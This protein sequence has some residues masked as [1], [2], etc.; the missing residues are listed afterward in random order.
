MLSLARSALV[1]T[2]LLDRNNSTMKNR[3]FGKHG[4]KCPEIG[5]GAWSIGGGCWGEQADIDSIAALNRV[6]YLGCNFI[7]TAADHGNGR[8][9]KFI[10][11]VLRERAAAGKTDK[12]FV[13]TKTPPSPGIWPPS[14][15]CKGEKRS[16]KTYLRENIA[17]SDLPNLAPELLEKLRRHNWRRGLWCG[18]K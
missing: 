14:P 11:Q 18:G 12:V 7:D 4:F 3:P 15:Y 5:F 2:P 17:T 10:A 1:K 8:S 9:E 13:A 6:L 16:S